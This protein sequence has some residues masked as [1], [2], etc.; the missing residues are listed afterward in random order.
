MLAPHSR[1][2]SSCQL[3][4]GR[5]HTSGHH[6]HQMR[7]VFDI[8]HRLRMAGCC[9]RCAVNGRACA[10]AK[11]TSGTEA[12]STKAAGVMWQKTLASLG[13]NRLHCGKEDSQISFAR[14][15]TV[16]SPHFGFASVRLVLIIVNFLLPNCLVYAYAYACV[17]VSN[18]PNSFRYNVC[19]I[20]LRKLQ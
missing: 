12:R 15:Y 6:S 20:L 4:A 19:I 5:G 8:T 9:A 16:C 11:H 2:S 13:K 14:R 1:H 3:L 18:I 10:L 17:S 7:R